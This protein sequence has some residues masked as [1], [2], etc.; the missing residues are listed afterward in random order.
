MHL[1]ELSDKQGVDALHEYA[2]IVAYNVFDII[3]HRDIINEFA[4]GDVKH[5][6]MQGPE[7]LFLAQAGRKPVQIRQIEMRANLTTKRDER[8]PIGVP[9]PDKDMFVHAVNQRFFAWKMPEN[10]RVGDT[11][12]FGQ[13]SRLPFKSLQMQPLGLAF[14]LF[15]MGVQA[16]ISSKADMRP[17]ILQNCYQLVT[18]D[19][20][21]GGD[22]EVKARDF[23]Y[24]KAESVEAA[25]ALFHGCDGEARYLAGGQSL[26]PAL[27]LRLDA[28]DL[29]IDIAHLDDLCVISVQN[30]ELCI[31]ALVRHADI[32][33]SSLVAKHA[34]LLAQAAAYVAH[35]AIRNKGTMGGSLALA[36]P[37]AEFPAIMLALDAQIDVRGVDG[38]RSVPADAFF[39]GLYETA[40]TMGD[41]IIG[42]RVPLAMPQMRFAFDELARRRGDYAL[43]GLGAALTFSGETMAAARLAFLSVGPSPVRARNAEAALVGRTL[44]EAAI[45]AA[46]AALGDDLAPDDDVNLSG[47]A[48]LHMARVLLGRILAKLTTGA[49]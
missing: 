45:K 37:S 4:Q 16:D 1:V 13:L 48:R 47:T 33:S 31:G 21:Q 34:P 38:Q 15:F 40:L 22:I 17:M 14:R 11:K 41:L 6:A 36:D 3:R 9:A 26:L 29:L 24:S 39:L 2:N 7:C 12:R 43:V 28:P 30:N 19:G 18:T 35:P 42:I 23:A 25:L 27:N 8:L 32:L 49:H 46:K 44:D 10:G 20:C 5:F